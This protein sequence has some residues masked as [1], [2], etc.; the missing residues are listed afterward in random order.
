MA[1]PLYR[2]LVDHFDAFRGRYENRFERQY[3]RWRDV[4]D[5]VVARYLE[6]GVLEAGFSRVRCDDCRAEY[7]LAFSCKARYFCPS[8]H[9][10]RLGVWSPWLEREILAPVP[11]RQFVF[12]VPKRLRPYFLW[13]RSLLGDLARIA[14]ATTTEVIR[15]TIGEPDLSV[16]IALSIQTTARW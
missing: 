2:L 1:S 6:C 11:H 10:K 3:G 7:N 15:A 8:C 9:A 14:A 13:R 12:T 4:V 5:E 16:G